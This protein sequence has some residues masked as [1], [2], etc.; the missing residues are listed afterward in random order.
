MNLRTLALPLLLAACSPVP[1]AA[2][3]D[4]ATGTAAA[5]ADTQATLARYHWRL[6]SALTADGARI[7]ALFA[8]GHAPLQ[9]DFADGRVHVTNACNSMGGSARI[10]NARLVVGPMISTMMAC[11]DPAVNGL[12]HAIRSRLGDRPALK[13]DA[14]AAPPTLRLTTADGDELVFAGAATAETRY[15]SPGTTVFLEVAAHTVSC[16]HPLMPHA[17]CLRVREVQYDADGLRTG[18]PGPWHA[19]AA[20]IEGFTAQDGVHYVVRVRR[21]A[22]HPVPAD[23]P[24]DAYVLDTVVESGPPSD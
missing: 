7:D 21:Y 3:A 22:R 18:T 16:R 4:A 15:G 5:T 8:P 17:Q 1:P 6:Q 2:P 10:E 12:D 24:S 20:P 11:P 13:L 19:L 9:L 14:D 23:A